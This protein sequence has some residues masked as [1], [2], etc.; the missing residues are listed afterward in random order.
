VA[1]GFSLD[2]DCAPAPSAVVPMA[3]VTTTHAAIHRTYFMSL[4]LDLLQNGS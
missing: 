1:F 2:D 4:P 3:N